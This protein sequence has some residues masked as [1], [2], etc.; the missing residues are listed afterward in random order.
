MILSQRIWR[1]IED[2]ARHVIKAEPLWADFLAKVILAYSSLGQALSA[3]LA[4]ELS[5]ESL[6]DFHPFFNDMLN[7]D[8]E[9]AFAQ[10]LDAILRRD[11]ACIYFLQAFLNFKGFK[12][13][14]AYRFMHASWLAGHKMTALILQGRIC[15]IW[16]VDIHPAA[17]IGSAVMIDHAC[18]VVIGETA[19]V[20]DEV[21]LLQGVTL[22]GVSS[23][24]TDR[25][26]K[27]R[28]G[29]FIGANSSVLGNI[30]IGA[31]AKIAAGSVV[32]KD[33]PA[34]KT[35]VGAPARIIDKNASAD[36]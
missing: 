1:K 13:I 6:P 11:P 24:R 29:V 32:L 26:P 9:Q 33:V 8:M 12:S 17:L 21:W 27:V 34:H 20:E 25:H 10:D 15:D 36:V 14:S 3:Y 28:K 23:Q 30:E 2:E 5:T 19:V 16:D 18:A 7:D 35:A 22:G 4:N 31:Y